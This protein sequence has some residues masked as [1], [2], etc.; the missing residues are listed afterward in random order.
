MLPALGYSL[1]SFASY[2]MGSALH[3]DFTLRKTITLA[4]LD[5]RMHLT[6]SL[7][8]VNVPDCT[9]FVS[10]WRHATVVPQRKLPVKRLDLMGFLDAFENAHYVIRPTLGILV[11]VCQEEFGS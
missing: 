8:T 5:V 1:V 7:T 2:V 6:P 3:R 4:V 10:F 9:T 11:I